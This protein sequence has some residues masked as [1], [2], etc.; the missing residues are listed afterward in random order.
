MANFFRNSEDELRNRIVN[1]EFDHIPGAWNKMSKLLDK[2]SAGFFSSSNLLWMVPTI[3]AVILSSI[4]IYGYQSKTEPQNPIKTP[5]AEVLST[6]EPQLKHSYNN[7]HVEN[8]QNF[9]G[10]SSVS[11]TVS[12]F[13]TSEASGTNDLPKNEVV[14]P[15]K[16]TLLNNKSTK[17]SNLFDFDSHPQEDNSFNGSKSSAS[18]MNSDNSDNNEWLNS[19]NS[20]AENND[21][22]V[23][24]DIYTSKITNNTY[25]EISGSTII[26][27]NDYQNAKENITSVDQENLAP[28]FSTNGTNNLQNSVNYTT[29]H[30]NSPN[31]SFESLNIKAFQYETSDLKSL[32]IN[33]NKSTALKTEPLTF[34]IDKKKLRLPIQFISSIGLSTKAIGGFD[35]LSFSPNASIAVSKRLHRLHS[36][37]L[38]IAYNAIN[39]FS[40]QANNSE[41]NQMSYYQLADTYNSYSLK[42]VDMLE[43]PLRYNFHLNKHLAF[44]AGLKYTYLINIESVNPSFS[45]DR[46]GLDRHDLGIM[47][48]VEV[49]INQHW[50]VLVNYNY[51]LFNLSQSATDRFNDMNISDELAGV[52]LVK[53]HSLLLGNNEIYNYVES[54]NNTHSFIRLP[55]NL[56]NSDLNLSIRYKF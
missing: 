52:D 48:G 24:N 39:N 51:G 30:N 26:E 17:N 10:E 53:K 49:S 29:N 33:E 28:S 12:D 40:D 50:S 47:M 44:N 35:R 41:L 37:E 45:A 6:Q 38:G 21:Q 4:I 5:I 22:R 56:R 7:P 13:K 2:Q 25:S 32:S 31:T 23:S 42:R 1:H 3:T 14:V 54:Q 18:S 20:L 46:I 15:K 19:D 8:Q 43:V 55:E 34:S 36:I 16:S 11:G 9:S 27:N